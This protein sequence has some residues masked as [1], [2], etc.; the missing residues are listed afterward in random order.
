MYFVIDDAEQSL[1]KPMW[2]RDKKNIVVSGRVSLHLK[3]TRNSNETGK[4]FFGNTNNSIL[5]TYSLFRDAS[6]DGTILSLANK[7]FIEE[8]LA[9]G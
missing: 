1:L 2:A 8:G 9:C 3:N 4:L 7:H 5:Y 6:I